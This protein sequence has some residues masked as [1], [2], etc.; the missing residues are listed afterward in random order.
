MEPE[1]SNLQH[2]GLHL[3]DA[4]AHTYT[5][6]R[7]TIQTQQRAGTYCLWSKGQISTLLSGNGI[8]PKCQGRRFVNLLCK[9][10]Y[11]T[12]YCLALQMENN[13]WLDRKTHR[14][15]GSKETSKRWLVGKVEIR[16]SKWEQT[17]WKYF[18]REREKE[19][20]AGR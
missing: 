5:K 1:I 11:W 3:V 4:H 9:Y 12:L 6:N 14:Q 10:V 19:K 18:M 2:M 13:Q 8:V 16:D 7:P 17:E 15:G 20:G